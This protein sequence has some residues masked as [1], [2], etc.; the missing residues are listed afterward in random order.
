MG[1][2]RSLT[3][4][5]AFLAVLWGSV[6]SVRAD[7]LRLHVVEP[8]NSIGLATEQL[9]LEVTG[10]VGYVSFTSPNSLAPGLVVPSFPT[11]FIT[12]VHFDDRAGILDSLTAILGGPGAGF[13]SST[14][15]VYLPGGDNLPPDFHVDFL[16]GGTSG[17][18]DDPA[19]AVNPGAYLRIGFSRA[20]IFDD[21]LA[22]L[23]TGAGDP[24]GSERTRRVGVD[25]RPLVG[26]AGGQ[27]GDEFVHRAPVP[28]AV[29]LAVFGLGVVGLSW[30]RFA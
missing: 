13:T 19:Q 8:H 24:T 20:S 29:L 14:S 2:R 1:R 10:S 21:L 11:S 25:I 15:P 16:A 28:G 26:V 4:R 17:N 12:Q 27:T 22:A 3:Y 23:H 9:L 30:R 18:G 6:V 5:A 7:M